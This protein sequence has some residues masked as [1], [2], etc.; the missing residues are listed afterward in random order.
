MFGAMLTN[1]LY[2]KQFEAHRRSLTAN[3]ALQ[4]RCAAAVLLCFH[5]AA[6]GFARS[7]QPTASGK[8]QRT[9]TLFLEGLVGCFGSTTCLSG[10]IKRQLRFEDPVALLTSAMDIFAQLDLPASSAAP[11]PDGSSA[12]AAGR[13]HTHLVTVAPQSHLAMACIMDMALARL[14]QRM[15]QPSPEV[16]AA[17][18]EVGQ[19]LVQLAP[20]FAWLFRS[21]ASPAAQPALLAVQHETGGNLPHDLLVRLCSVSEACLRCTSWAQ[22]ISSA[23]ELREW[24]AAAEAALRLLPLAV[25]YWAQFGEPVRTERRREQGL[26]VEPQLEPGLVARDLVNGCLGLW[27]Q[28]VRMADGYVARVLS[29]QAAG[30]ELPASEQAAQLAPLLWQLHGSSTTL[31]ARPQGGRGS[32]R[33]ALRRD[34]PTPALRR[35]GPTWPKGSPK[36]SSAVLACWR[37]CWTEVQHLAR[38]AGGGLS[39]NGQ[40]CVVPGMSRFSPVCLQVDAGLPLC[41]ALDSGVCADA[42]F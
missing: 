39:E 36:P 33:A 12:A 31:L 32:C 2:L 7:P 26:T 10:E 35:G 1:L 8:P 9:D 25:D 42:A 17:L 5:A 18:P 30:V 29:A 38:D 28:A 27:S 37:L 14:E 4:Q 22:A 11:A 34:G 40:R 24:S 15:A 41:C 21:L 16:P 19:R 3:A 13:S 20:R 23:E 6:R